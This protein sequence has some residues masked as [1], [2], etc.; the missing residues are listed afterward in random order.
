MS[1]ARDMLERAAAAERELRGQEF[2]APLVPRGRAHMRISG[3]LYE[4]KVSGVQRPGFYVCRVQDARSATIV[5]PAQPWQVGEYLRLFRALRLVLLER[6]GDQGTWLALPYNDSDARQRF[7]IAGP[8]LIYAVEGGQ[9]FDRV[10]ARYDSALWFEDLDRRADPVQA[11]AL[12]SA[13]VA[14]QPTPGLPGLAPGQQLAYTLRAGAA[15]VAAAATPT[16]IPESPTRRLS[17]PPTQPQTPQRVDR[18]NQRL[19]ESLNVSGATL[20]GYERFGD[21]VLVRWSVGGSSR[22]PIR[23]SADGSVVSSG[24]CL[25]GR[26]SQFDLTSVV[27][28]IERSPRY[29]RESGGW[30]DS[31]YDDD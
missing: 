8:V 23:L 15:V 11:D 4:L 26:D 1:S 27:G 18:L 31:D 2:L 24:I 7:G 21:E 28:V 9:P 20:E 19:Q 16:A 12:R 14:G 29:A 25:S 30:Y 6:I 13:L 22:P 10:I 3:L 17:G 5:S